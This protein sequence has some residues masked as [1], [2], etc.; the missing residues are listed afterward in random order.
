MKEKKVY[1][2]VTSSDRCIYLTDLRGRKQSIHLTKSQ[3]IKVGDKL[4][5]VGA[6]ADY[7]K[8]QEVLV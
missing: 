1:F 2:S 4:M 5:K 3:A 7:G 8:G 6:A